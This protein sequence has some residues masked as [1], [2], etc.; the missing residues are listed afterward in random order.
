VSPETNVTGEQRSSETWTA[1][2]PSSS[3]DDVL[4]DDGRS[5]E[6]LVDRAVGDL[7]L[8]VAPA[9]LTTSMWD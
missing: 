5:V 9:V 2:R 8:E 6:R 3:V 4:V 7:R 1:V